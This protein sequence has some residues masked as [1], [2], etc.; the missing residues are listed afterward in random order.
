MKIFKE[1]IIPILEI[2]EMGTLSNLFYKAHYHNKTRQGHYKNR[3]NKQNKHRIITPHEHR[4][5]NS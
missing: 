5:N 1:E 4:C 3:K 2:Q